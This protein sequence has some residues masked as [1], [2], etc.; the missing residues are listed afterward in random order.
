MTTWSEKK[1]KKSPK[2]KT[3]R[4]NKQNPW[5]GSGRKVSQGASRSLGGPRRSHISSF[6]E[7]EP[8]LGGSFATEM[9]LY[10]DRQ[11]LWCSWECGGRLVWAGGGGQGANFSFWCQLHKISGPEPLRDSSAHSRSLYFIVTF[12]LPNP[13]SIGFGQNKMFQNQLIVYP[14]KNKALQ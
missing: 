10:G 14:H 11:R 1:W 7:L 8:G 6:S 5:I 13:M 2:T 4:T 9:R 3:Q 12:F